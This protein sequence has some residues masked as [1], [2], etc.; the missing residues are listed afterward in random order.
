[1]MITQGTQTTYLPSFADRPNGEFSYGNLPD[2]ARMRQNAPTVVRVYANLASG[3]VEGVEG[4]PAVLYGGAFNRQGSPIALPGSPLLPVGGPRKLS[5]GPATPPN[6]ELS[7]ETE[8]YTFV[9]PASWSQQESI[10]VGVAMLPTQQTQ[11]PQRSVAQCLTEA[12]KAN[13]GMRIRHIR[14]DPMRRRTIRPVRMKVNNNTLP[15]PQDVFAYT[16]LV[17]PP[18]LNVEPYYSTIDISSIANG[19][20]TN[21][22]KDKKAASALGEWACDHSV[23]DDGW[24][25]GI[26]TGVGNG[27]QTGIQ[28]YA[29]P[30]ATYYAVVE[31]KRPLSS[32]AHEFGHL[33]GLNHASPGCDADDE[34]SPYDDWPPDEQGFTQSSGLDLRQ[35]SGTTGPFAVMSEPSK[36]WFDAMSYCGDNNLVSNFLRAGSSNKWI[37]VRYWNQV[38]DSFEDT[39]RAA[40]LQ[41]RAT[42]PSLRVTGY[43]SGASAEISSVTPIRAGEAPTSNSPYH[44]LGLDAGGGTL[45]DVTMQENT[46]HVDGG[47][48]EL[49]LSG[50]IPSADV[51]AVAIARDGAIIA[52]RDAS[53]AAPTLSLRG[54]PRFKRGNATIR[55]TQDDADGDPLTTAISY[56]A[57]GKRFERIWMGVG[58]SSATVPAQYLQRARSARIRVTVNDGF[59]TTDA[60][61]KPF[62]SPGAKPEVRIL[63]PLRGAR[64]P[65]DARLVLTGEAFDDTGARLGRKQL[66]WRAG[67]RVLGRGESVA[68]LG[69]PPGRRRITLTATDRFGR[70]GRASVV[71][72]LRP[73][74]PVLL[75]ARGPKSVGQKA[76][77][78]KLRVAASIPARLTVRGQRFKVDRRVRRIRVKVRRGTKPLALTLRVAAG[79]RASVTRVRI[80]R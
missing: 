2:V 73:A 34:A 41:A 75:T 1:M 64:Q 55:W 69:L 40:P 27:L 57:N 74:T 4:V 14:L 22:E 13:D 56:A 39:S 49:V 9:L 37:S 53:G 10:G 36:N 6:S 67:K 79:G 59:R 16:R 35:G 50:V 61:S 77:R 18:R 15:D 52:R 44:L 31:Y 11:Q 20:G 5:V 78:V 45:V 47:D 3:P 42:E 23:P 8:V 46:Q 54:T 68:P 38:F 66:V 51:R 7:S 17:Y 21:R 76:R 12:C 43:G 63:S 72:R 28:C 19:T 33:L 25:V 30:R 65:I 29:P 71:V 24:A 60:T 32:S 48:D 58:K 26:Y 70:R 80:K 62:R